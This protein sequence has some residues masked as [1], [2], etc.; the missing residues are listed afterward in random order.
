M[1]EQRKNDSNRKLIIMK[2]S[3]HTTIIFQDFFSFIMCMIRLSYTLDDIIYLYASR[4]S[5]NVNSL[6]GHY[7]LFCRTP[8]IE[9][10]KTNSS[11][12]LIGLWPWS[13]SKYRTP[14]NVEFINQFIFRGSLKIDLEKWKKENFLIFKANRKGSWN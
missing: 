7:N 1:K 3:H 9:R 2:N 13:W 12:W 14:N 4:F 6:T 11:G 8:Q 5:R 10:H